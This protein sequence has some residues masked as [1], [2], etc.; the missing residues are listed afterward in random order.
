MSNN[1]AADLAKQMGESAMIAAEGIHSAE[2]SGLIDT[3]VYILN[4]QYS[5]SLYG[6]I[7]NNRVFTFAGDPSTGKCARGSEMITVYCD[8]TTAERL[9]E[10]L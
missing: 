9:K 7:P 4:A 8:E 10:I 3:G 2:V 6:G 1:F 5:G